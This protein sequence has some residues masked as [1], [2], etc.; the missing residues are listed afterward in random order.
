MHRAAFCEPPPPGSRST[1]D[2]RTLRMDTRLVLT[3][4]AGGRPL[5][6][7]TGT[8][9][10]AGFIEPRVSASGASRRS[11]LE[12]VASCRCDSTACNATGTSSAGGIRIGRSSPTPRRRGTSG[13]STSSSRTGER[14][15]DDV[16]AWVESL[17]VTTRRGRALDFGCGAGRISQALG[18]SLRTRGRRGHRPF[19]DCARQPAQSARRTLP[20]RAERARGP[21]AV[22]GLERRLPLQPAGAAT[23]PAERDQGLCRRV[24]AGFSTRA[25]SRCSTCPLLRWTRRWPAALSRRSRRCFSSGSIAAPSHARR[26][27]EIPQHGSER[28]PARRAGAATDEVGRNR[29]VRAARIRLTATP[30]RGSW[31]CITVKAKG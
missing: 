3:A 22:P 7:E 24:R 16:L 15:V 9:A 1:C 28:R 17:G 8:R 20:L 2:R 10:E 18:A 29:R 30:G 14:E 4:E 13:I 19:D 25:A 27:M 11:G 23:S 5:G 26:P 21:A 6:H 12:P 31:Y